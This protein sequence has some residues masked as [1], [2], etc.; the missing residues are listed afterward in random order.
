MD[1]SRL[2]LHLKENEFFKNLVEKKP[3]DQV[4]DILSKLKYEFRS[5]GEYVFRHGDIATSLYIILEGKVDLYDSFCI[6]EEKT[7]TDFEPI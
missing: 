1:L 7:A 5:E 2:F 4:L 3:L 6:D